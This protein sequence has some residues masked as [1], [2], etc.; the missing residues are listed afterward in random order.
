MSHS[1]KQSRHAKRRQ[2]MLR[3]MTIKKR[4]REEASKRACHVANP[5]LFLLSQKLFDVCVYVVQR[6]VRLARDGVNYTELL[7]LNAIESP[8]SL[9]LPFASNEN[10][11]IAAT[12]TMGSV[13][14]LFKFLS[15][16]TFFTSNSPIWSFKSPCG[17]HS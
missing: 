12:P 5:F 11:L 8:L 13:L 7:L 2:N 4:K 14:Q 17:G 10:A 15:A 16:N 9:L 3:R 6:G 1:R